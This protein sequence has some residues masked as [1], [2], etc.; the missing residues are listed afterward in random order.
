MEDRKFKASKHRSRHPGR[1]RATLDLPL[2]V[3]HH[4]P[5]LLSRPSSMYRLLP[6]LLRRQR[7]RT[8]AFARSEEKPRVTTR[9]QKTGQPFHRV[10][11][12]P[13]SDQ[14]ADL[15]ATA[16]SCGLSMCH[17]VALM[18]EL[19]RTTPPA[20]KKGGVPQVDERYVHVEWVSYRTGFLHRLTKF[21]RKARPPGYDAKP[22]K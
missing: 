12:R 7:F 21:R 4:F 11:F 13:D 10:H 14:W 17:F 2:R 20:R 18:L 19:D 16:R 3:L 8:I 22:M 1:P 6:A 15:R 5:E 9:Y